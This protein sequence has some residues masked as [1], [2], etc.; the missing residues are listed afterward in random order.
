MCD[1]NNRHGVEH[2]PFSLSLSNGFRS[3]GRVGCTGYSSGEAVIR[4]PKSEE[5]GRFPDC[6]NNLMKTPIRR[7]TG[8]SGSF[9]SST[10]HHVIDAGLGRS[11]S[12][13]TAFPGHGGGKRARF[14]ASAWRSLIIPA[15][16]PGRCVA[17]GSVGRCETRTTS[18]I[19]R[20]VFGSPRPLS[21]NPLL[22][23][24]SGF[25][26]LPTRS[27]PLPLFGVG[28]SQAAALKRPSVWGDRLDLC[29]GTVVS[30]S[31]PVSGRV[32]RDQSQRFRSLHA[33]EMVGSAASIR[34]WL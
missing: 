24:T 13:Q 34:G 9:S 26:P 16:R 6:R 18:S 11:A 7:T 27:C 2:R 31:V 23:P 8:Q 32:A 10:C 12:G 3:N 21:T 28:D 25:D 17:R 22:R 4:F 20:R 19:R 30:D 29:L 14:E 33:P 15:A 1:V 5:C